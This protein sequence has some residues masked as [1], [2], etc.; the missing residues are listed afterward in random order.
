[1]DHLICVS[2]FDNIM[3]LTAEPMSLFSCVYLIEFSGVSSSWLGFGDEDLGRA[4]AA[5][6]ASADG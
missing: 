5:L 6:T 4:L 2:F 3:A 1:M